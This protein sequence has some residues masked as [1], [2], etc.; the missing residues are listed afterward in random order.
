MRQGIRPGRPVVQILMGVHGGAQ[1]LPDQLRSI[2]RQKGVRWRL[3][4]SDDGSRD[5]SRQVLDGFA[6][7]WPGRVRVVPGPQQG[8]AA[9]FLHLIGGLPVDPGLVALADQDDIWLPVKLARAAAWLGAV[10]PVRPAL[11]CARRIVWTPAH[12][13]CRAEWGGAVTPS[14]RNALIENIAPG[15]TIVLNQAAARLARL[16]ARQVGPV[17]AHDWWLYLLVTGAGGTVLADP[18]PMLLYRQHEANALGAGRGL[19]AQAR[20]K[21]GVLRG[22]YRDR[23]GLNIAA[24]R[25]CAI[26]LTPAN[27]A[28][29][30][31]FE[32]ARARRAARDIYR[33]GR[34][35]RPYRQSGIGCAAFWG[36]ALLGKV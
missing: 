16:A 19:C 20:R 21:A 7:L 36:A 10:D 17:F 28:V 31:A 1:T 11:Y 33:M 26:H 23:L 5:A 25:R 4:C 30:D 13:S 29:L 24:M 22:E 8:F 27:R 15:N 12:D 18:E 35:A 34:A 9:N 32:A 6:S 14:F 3:T 2:A